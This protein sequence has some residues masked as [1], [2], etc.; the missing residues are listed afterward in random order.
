M[1]RPSNTEERREQIAEALLS[2]M[3]K[4]GWQH[5]TIQLIAKSARLSPGLLHYHF[6]DKEEIL[7]HLVERLVARLD[8]RVEARLAR[9]GTSP[10][11]RLHALVDAH[12]ALGP[13]ADRD[14]VA[15]WV[16]V[17]GEAMRSR[18]VREVHSRALTKTLVRIEALVRA[19]APHVSVSHVS[20]AILA[21]IEGAYVL[22]VSAAPGLLPIGYAAPAVRALVDGIIA[23]PR[24]R[25]RRAAR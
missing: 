11:A 7:V 5:A 10:R 21:A 16:V 20:A 24:G 13:D 18:D 12:L 1:G 4:H 25:S 8:H 2:V 17:A 6:R 19:A 14:T 23:T 3:A 9:A 22:S 15:A